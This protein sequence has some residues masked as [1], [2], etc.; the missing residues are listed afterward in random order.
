MKFNVDVKE[1][2]KDSENYFIIKTN[3]KTYCCKKLI[4][5]TGLFKP[6]SLNVDGAIKYTDL[7]MEKNKFENKKILIKKINLIKFLYIFVSA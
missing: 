1:I 5:A 4:L 2:S 6:H 3:E 7:N